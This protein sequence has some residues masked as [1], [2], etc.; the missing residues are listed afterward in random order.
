M[1]IQWIFKIQDIAACP[2]LVTLYEETNL[3]GR[4]N[5]IYSF[6]LYMIIT[7]HVNH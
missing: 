7:I 5:D 4:L 2:F 1:V 6:V 3:N